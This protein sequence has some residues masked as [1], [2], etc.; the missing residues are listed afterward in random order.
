MS[1]SIAASDLNDEFHHCF[2]YHALKKGFNKNL[3]FHIQCKVRYYHRSLSDDCINGTLD[4]DVS[5]DCN[6]IENK[7]KDRLILN[8][9]GH[10][11][12][13][14]S[15]LNLMCIME[16]KD[17]DS[18][19]WRVER[20]N[21][22]KKHLFLQQFAINPPIR[23]ISMA[24][25]SPSYA[26]F[27]SG[28]RSYMTEIPEQQDTTDTRNRYKRT[29]YDDKNDVGLSDAS[30]TIISIIV[31]C[32]LLLVFVS[33]IYLFRYQKL[34][35]K[36]LE[37]NLEFGNTSIGNQSVNSSFEVSE[38]NIEDQQMANITNNQNTIDSSECPDCSILNTL[39]NALTESENLLYPRCTVDIEE[40]I[41]HGNYGSVLKG[42]LRM[43]NAR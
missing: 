15:V 17:D 2:K 43:G 40:K 10:L 19:E 3:R 34:K 25:T 6:Y 24:H 31:T 42:Y 12:A 29:K 32:I 41:G 28:S 11:K 16:T 22:W 20:N 36:T 26:S 9:E 27:E 38:P 14:K 23:L 1:I 39:P 13:T 21:G 4:S 7:L 30:S 18:K 37:R 35:T 8:L 5:S 33:G